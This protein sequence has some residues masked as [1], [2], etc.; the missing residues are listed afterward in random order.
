[1]LSTVPHS[2]PI[3]MDSFWQR[4]LILIRRR[5]N[6]DYC[7]K[8]LLL[9]QTRLGRLSQQVTLIVNNFILYWLVVLAHFSCNLHSTSYL[10][11]QLV[12]AW[13]NQKLRGASD[14]STKLL[15]ALPSLMLLI[16]LRLIRHWC[17]EMSSLLHLHGHLDTDIDFVD[18]STHLDSV[19]FI[20]V[21]GRWNFRHWL[22]H[23]DLG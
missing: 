13:V 3:I 18:F 15:I 14:T 23:F 17:S 11:I 10:L 1:M 5:C 9:M 19:G 21:W 7:M 20:G 12:A 4:I 16:V 6:W 8:L 22:V 2:T